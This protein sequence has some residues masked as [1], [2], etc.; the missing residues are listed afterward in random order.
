MSSILGR[1]APPKVI[2][3]EVIRLFIRST[4]TRPICIILALFY[5]RFVSLLTTLTKD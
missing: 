1:L 3:T 5:T 2:K 4:L